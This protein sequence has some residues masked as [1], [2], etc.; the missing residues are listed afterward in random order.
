MLVELNL[1][2]TLLHKLAKEFVRL[3]TEKTWHPHRETNTTFYTHMKR[4]STIGHWRVWG[5]YSLS[6]GRHKFHFPCRGQASCCPSWSST[7]PHSRFQS[8]W[9]ISCRLQSGQGEQSRR[10]PTTLVCLL[11][12]MSSDCSASKS[13]T[14]MQSLLQVHKNFWSTGDSAM[15]RMLFLCPV[16]KIFWNSQKKAQW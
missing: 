3:W 11:P 14:M 9:W 2:I 5:I 7:G 13:H 6:S 8:V 15:A 1:V 16:N 4:Q 10:T 12:V